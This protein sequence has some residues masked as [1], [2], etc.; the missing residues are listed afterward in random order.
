MPFGNTFLYGHDLRSTGNRPQHHQAAQ[1][2]LPS[3]FTG[4]FCR[5][6]RITADAIH[7]LGLIAHQLGKHTL[8]IEHY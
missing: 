6:N 7:N 1:L 8:A 5:L 3:S 4:R 2:K